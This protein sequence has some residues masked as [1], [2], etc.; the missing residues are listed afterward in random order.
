MYRYHRGGCSGRM[1]LESASVTSDVI[2]LPAIVCVSRNVWVFHA[3]S[4]SHFLSPKAFAFCTP[5]SELIAWSVWWTSFPNDRTNKFQFQNQEMLLFAIGSG[6]IQAKICKSFIICALPAA[7]QRATSMRNTG[8]RLGS[9]QHPC[10][11]ASCIG[12]TAVSRY[13]PCLFNHWPTLG[14]TRETSRPTTPHHRIYWAAKMGLGKMSLDIIDSK[15]F[16]ILLR[17][18]IFQQEVRPSGAENPSPPPGYL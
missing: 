18:G 1:H 7:F 15:D 14:W 8:F 5:V 3:A 10:K 2:S 12:N 11:V 4:F 17:A 16:I 9:I 6:T 13:V